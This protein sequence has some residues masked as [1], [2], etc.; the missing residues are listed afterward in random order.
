MKL[1]SI[2]SYVDAGGVSADI[3]SP[4][5]PFLVGGPKTEKGKRMADARPKFIKWISNS[6]EVQRFPHSVWHCELSPDFKYMLVQSDEARLG[7]LE[8][9]FLV[10]ADGVVS[11]VPAPDFHVAGKP[12]ELFV[13]CRVPD[14]CVFS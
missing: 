10:T 7:A 1:F 12:V 8:N 14:D 9:I 6:G 5:D 11:R 4:D 2:A 13:S 3:G